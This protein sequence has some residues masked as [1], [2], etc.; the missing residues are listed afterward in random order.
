MH[1]RLLFFISL[2]AVTLG[3]IGQPVQARIKCWTNNEGVRECG[4]KV[5]PEFAQKGHQELSKQGMLV[6]EQDRA[7][8]QEELE[9]EARLAAI[10]VEKKKQ[11]EEQAKEDRVLLQTFSNVAD[12]ELVRNEQL[13]ALEA[14]INV[15]ITRSE[16]IQ[17]DLDDRIAQAAAQE[18][19][20]N[21]PNK[22]L[23]NDIES[24]RR[25][26]DT[27]NKFVED[28]R[29][30]QVEIRKDYDKRIARFKELRGIK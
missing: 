10:E 14:N 28:K 6:E 21:T 26:I 30:E 24:L 4:E 5:P 19:A 12:I 22:E 7:K 20:G 13:K 11:E 1:T 29:T 16:K 18:R 2:T 15:T 17:Q 3:G 9:E 23:L 25:Q 27:N 8:T